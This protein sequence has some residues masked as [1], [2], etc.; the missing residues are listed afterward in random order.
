MREVEREV[1]LGLMNVKVK[2]EK[3]NLEAPTKTR[4]GLR[5]LLAKVEC[6]T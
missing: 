5:N 1:L 6:R 2:D 4:E 3:R